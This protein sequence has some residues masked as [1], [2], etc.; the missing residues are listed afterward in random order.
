[1]YSDF[2]DLV[3]AY[4]TGGTTG[5]ELRYFYNSEGALV[6]IEQYATTLSGGNGS[7]IELHSTITGCTL[8]STERYYYDSANRATRI[9]RQD[10]DGDSYECRWEYDHNNNVTNLVEIVNG[11]THTTSYTY[12]LEQR[13]S[14]FVNDG[15]TSGYT[16]D[17]F[18]RLITVSNGILSRNYQFQTVTVGEDSFETSR[19][20]ELTLDAAN[21]DRTYTYTY[22]ANGNILSVSDGTNTTSYV[23]DSLNQLVRENNQAAWKTWVYTY[24]NGGNIT[25]RTAYAYT[26]ARNPGAGSGPNAAPVVAYYTYGDTHWGDLLTAYKGQSITYDGI[27]NPLNDGTWTYTW[28]NGRQLASMTSGTTTWSYKYN[29]DG[30]RTERTNGTLTYDY[31]Y[32]GSQLIQMTVGTDTLYFTY[33]ASGVPMAVAFNGTKYFY[34]TNLQGDIIA[35]L[36]TDGHAVVEYTYDAW[37]NHLSTTGTMAN[38]LGAVNPLRYRGYV[39]D[40]ETALY[41]LQSRYYDPEMGRFINADALISTGQGLLGNNMFAYCNNNPTRYSD[42]TGCVPIYPVEFSGGGGKTQETKIPDSIWTKITGFIYGQAAF[43]YSNNRVGWGTYAANG[44]GIIAVY[45][46]LQLLEC[47]EPLGLIEAEISNTGGLWAGGLLGVKPWAIEKYFSS[48]GI[49]CTG[50]LSYSAMEQSLSEGD[51]IVFLVMN[52]TDN[53]IK[54][55]H[56]MVAQYLGN[57]FII[58]NYSNESESSVPVPTLDPVYGNAGWCYG[59]IIGG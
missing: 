49:S 47:P 23:Y 57:Q 53:I 21:Y 20:G 52:D 2:G 35:I 42:P 43:E 5:T 45:N 7:D 10:A 32:S 27:G 39:F 44:C 29:A 12:D 13:I 26:T 56:Y 58:Y 33:D 3:R 24:D 41:Y 34:A 55:Y 25:S 30:L 15:V 4:T 38:T 11:Q 40:S 1:M 37:G 19:I 9:I 46:V 48:R 36:D 6:R 17:G 18:G 54:G 59:F 22:D 28:E 8:V 31:I 50:Y 14:Q 51:I 16:Y